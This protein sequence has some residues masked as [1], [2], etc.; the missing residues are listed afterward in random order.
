M[1]S[2]GD[3]EERAGTGDG[4]SEHEAPKVKVPFPHARGVELNTSEHPGKMLTLRVQQ[5][6]ALCAGLCL[7][8]RFLRRNE[9]LW[10]SVSDIQREKC[11]HHSNH[12]PDPFPCNFFSFVHLTP[13]KPD[14][15]RRSP[16]A[17]VPTAYAECSHGDAARIGAATRVSSHGAPGPR[18]TYSH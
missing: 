9:C 18:A 3:C 13:D 10:R 1:R 6:C 16:D 11:S 2:A 15:F 8:Q 5:K 14:R 7:G 12:D 4:T 17:R